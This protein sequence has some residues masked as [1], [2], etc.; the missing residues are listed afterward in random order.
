M[1]AEYPA[2]PTKQS[3]PDKTDCRHATEDLWACH[4]VLTL[5]FTGSC[6]WS[7]KVVWQSKSFLSISQTTMKPQVKWQILWLQSCTGGHPVQ[8]FSWVC[9]ATLHNRGWTSDHKIG[10]VVSFPETDRA[11]LRSSSA[12]KGLLERCVNRETSFQN[13]HTYRF[14]NCRAFQ[15]LLVLERC[16][17]SS[18]V[19]AGFKNQLLEQSAVQE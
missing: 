14:L 7:R 19:E 15:K 1:H 4:I 8:G 2:K 16:R 6:E 13:H 12:P 9:P 5:S 17:D 11:L 10:I 3:Q 18:A